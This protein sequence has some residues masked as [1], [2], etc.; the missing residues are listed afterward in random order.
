M[1]HFFYAMIGLIGLTFLMIG[2]G[3]GNPGTFG[4]SYRQFV[5]EP[6]NPVKKVTVLSLDST[7]QFKLISQE[8]TV[9]VG[10]SEFNID[11]DEINWEELNT[12]AKYQAK[13]VNANVVLLSQDFV[14]EISKSKTVEVKSEF[15]QAAEKISL[16]A[17]G[18]VSKESSN[19]KSNTTGTNSDN[20]TKTKSKSSGFKLGGALNLGE[21]SSLIPGNV[22][23][24]QVDYE[25]ELYVIHAIYIRTNN[26][27]GLQK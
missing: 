13:R 26:Y 25:A 19:K 15:Q 11:S 27:P 1:K 5:L 3:T 18:E 2:C 9:V 7:S 14:K 20:T 21:L 10:K 8:G 16:G 4:T 12:Q 24:E 23:H 22:K 17:G 6:Q